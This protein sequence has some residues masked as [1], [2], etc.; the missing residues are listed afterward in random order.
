MNG[1]IIQDLKQFIAAAVSQ[2]TSIITE[3]ISRLDTKIDKLDKKLDDKTNV[4]LGAVGDTTSPRFEAVEA[5]VVELDT[6]VTKLE[7][8]TS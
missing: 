7:S 4:I 6:R 8:A 3:D 5:E 2:E 1:H